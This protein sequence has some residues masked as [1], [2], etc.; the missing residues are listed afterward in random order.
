MTASFVTILM[1]ACGTALIARRLRQPYTVVLVIAGLI[2]SFL[3]QHYP[4]FKAELDLIHLTPPLL[5]RLLLPILLFEAAFHLSIDSFMDNKR[6]ILFL[7]VPGVLVGLLLTAVLFQAGAAFFGL[8]VTWEQSLLI[9]SILAATDP[10]SVVALL[11]EFSVSRRL[12]IIIEG[13]SL[14]NDGIAV[15]VF[16]VILKFTS[17]SLG[18]A[19]PG[20]V[21]EQLDAF[22][23]AWE[24]VREVFAGAFFGVGVGLAVSFIHSRVNDHLIEVALTAIAAYGSNALA[25][26]FHASGV[27]SVVVAGMMCGNI[28]ARFGMSPVTK[29]AV[30]SFWEFAAFLANSFVFILIGL[31]INLER[32]WG[33]LGPIVLLFVAMIATRAV[34]IFITD[35]LVTR[36]ELRFEKGWT[37]AIIWGGI[38]GSLSMVLAV[39]LAATLGEKHGV[40]VQTRE[41]VIDLVFGVVLLS[42]ILQGTTMS[43]LLRKVG[44]TFESKEEHDYEKALARR[45]AVFALAREID[46]AAKSGTLSEE[47]IKQF[48]EVIARRREAVDGEISGMLERS[49][50]LIKV[51]AAM[52]AAHLQGVEKQTY[53][54]LEKSGDLDRDAMEEL[55]FEVITRH[56]VERSQELAH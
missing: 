17:E 31:E 20:D 55:V 52:F 15:V 44:L 18:L 13:E 33:Q 28:G 49:P 23:V 41:L 7:A 45:Q 14:L 24:F 47:S 37:P 43:W 53:R 22:T 42:I 50:E 48:H 21:H 51:E 27:M 26:N 25:L 6:P 19:I 54:H 36:G 3:Q 5:L 9:A 11:K 1:L 35:K 38:R 12:A 56:Q 32:L 4:G 46:E 39:S 29:E 40:G 2:I 16:G 10:I 30:F 8:A 34:I